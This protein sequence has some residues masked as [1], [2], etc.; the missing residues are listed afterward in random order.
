M[1]SLHCSVTRCEGDVKDNAGGLEAAF[2]AFSSQ[3]RSRLRAP[4][5]WYTFSPRLT[6]PS[7][8]VADSP[9]HP[10]V[11]DG[12]EQKFP[13]GERSA[14]KTSILVP[15]VIRDGGYGVPNHKYGNEEAQAVEPNVAHSH[16]PIVLSHQ[17][18]A[19]VFPSVLPALKSV[20]KLF[21]SNA[22]LTKDAAERADCQLFVQGDNATASAATQY[23]MAATLACP[24]K[25]QPFQNANR[26]LSGNPWQP[27]HPRQPR[28][29]SRA[30]AASARRETLPGRAR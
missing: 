2:F 25:A 8:S 20:N 7:L 21:G 15:P 30:G 13:D 14:K 27:R 22:S 11:E 26:P 6:E 3:S 24:M 19:A 9:R 4:F 12:K 16:R 23:D 28:R 29:S 17:P 5:P 1:R 10:E 18:G